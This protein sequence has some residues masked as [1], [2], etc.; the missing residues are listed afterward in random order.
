MSSGLKYFLGFLA[1]IAALIILFV[2]ILKGGS[3]KG[4][5]VTPKTPVDLTS[6]ID[7]NSEVSVFVEGRLNAEENHRSIRLT[8][9][10]NSRTEEVLK[11]YNYDTD[12]KQAF[13]NT[14]AAYDVLMH[15]LRNAGF[16]K[17]KSKPSN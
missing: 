15:A 3:N 16:T 13:P 6:L 11:G 5:P 2:L 1:V 8:I 10:A 9:S 17:E 14:Q 7:K 12:R 4:T